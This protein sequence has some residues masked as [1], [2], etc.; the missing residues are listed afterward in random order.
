M[1]GR[2]GRERK[3]GGGEKRRERKRGGRERKEG[4]EGERRGWKGRGEERKGEREVK[5]SCER[6]KIPL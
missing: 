2:E 4:G 5:A 3:K 1:K 6:T